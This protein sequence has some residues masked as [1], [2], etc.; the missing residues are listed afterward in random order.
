MMRINSFDDLLRHARKH[1]PVHVAV[2]GGADE[3][4]AAALGIAFEMG[5]I[6]HATISG[7]PLEIMALLPPNAQHCVTVLPAHT[8]AD[9]ATSAVSE[10]R[11]GRADILI[12]GAVDSGA[13]LKAVVNRATGISAS[14][15]L[16]NITIAALPGFD[17]L[18]GATD[19]GI[20]PAPDR[21]QKQAIILNSATL[22]CGLGISKPKVALVAATEK[23]SPAM[24]ATVDAACL[25]KQ[26][27]KG[28]ELAGPM[29]YDMAISP[30]A[31]SIKGADAAGVAGHADLLL[32]PNIEAANAV[33]KSWKFHANAQT[34]SIVLGGRVPILLNSRSDGAQARLNGLLLAIAMLA[35]QS[36]AN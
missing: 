16:S 34:G 31:A 28:F 5:L 15:V 8:P 9:M 20:V 3:Q 24:P 11:A 36:G 23:I 6:L 29:G 12:K 18:I 2:A 13:Y 27:L 26:G 21:E 4:V 1:G 32:F 14:G 30:R 35:G 10:V 17:R 25:V 33:V 19:N 22:W 7:D